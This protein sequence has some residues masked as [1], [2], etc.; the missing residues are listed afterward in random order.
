MENGEEVLKSKEKFHEASL[1]LEPVK[2]VI[3][4][5]DLRESVSEFLQGGAFWWQLNL[6]DFHGCWHWHCHLYLTLDLHAATIV[7]C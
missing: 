5:E 4:E 6:V 1:V 3:G 2:R 7:A